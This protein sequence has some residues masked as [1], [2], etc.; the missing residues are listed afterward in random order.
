MSPKRKIY[1]EW[2]GGP[3]DFELEAAAGPFDEPVRADYKPGWFYVSG[4]CVKPEG[5]QHHI[6][7]TLFA[8]QVGPDRFRMIPKSPWPP[9]NPHALRNLPNPLGD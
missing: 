4:L 5:F 1:V 2:P 9:V 7:R 6:T 8:E 3:Y